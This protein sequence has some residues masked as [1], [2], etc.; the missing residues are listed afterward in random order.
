MF[1]S[2]NPESIM[3]EIS[4]IKKH[5]ITNKERNK[6]I[7]ILKENG[8]LEKFLSLSKEAQDDEIREKTDIIPGLAVIIKNIESTVAKMEENLLCERLKGNKSEIRVGL[9][10]WITV[11]LIVGGVVSKGILPLLGL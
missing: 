5:K 10:W 7:A 2:R 6:H 8:D 3:N 9:I 11:S 4:N 1:Y